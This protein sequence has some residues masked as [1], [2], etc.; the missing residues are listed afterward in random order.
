M[1]KWLSQ[2]LHPFSHILK[3]L[4]GIREPIV[5]PPSGDFQICSI[6]WKMLFFPEKTL[7]TPSKSAY[8]CRQHLLL[9][10][11]TASPAPLS[12]YRDLQTLKSKKKHHVLLRQRA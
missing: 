9:N 7:Q 5:A 8:K 2:T 10:N 4:S 11:A 3:I 6:Q 12:D 1:P